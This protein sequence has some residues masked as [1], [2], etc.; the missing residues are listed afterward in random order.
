M[1]EKNLKIGYLLDFY[2]DILSERKRLVMSYY[3]NDD[4]SLG[5]IAEEIGISRQG[6]RDLIKKAEEELSFYEEKLGMAKRFQ[7]I[8]TQAEQLLEL[9]ELGG[10]E[11]K[12]CRLARELTETAR[13]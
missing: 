4:L 9:L 5:E 2:G 13:S 12:A 10:G 1:F 6:V 8:R 3:Y 11:E 7:L